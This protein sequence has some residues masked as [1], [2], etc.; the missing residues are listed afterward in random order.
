MFHNGHLWQRICSYLDQNPSKPVIT[1]SNTVCANASDEAANR[2]VGVRC[3]TK[4][5]GSGK[6]TRVVKRQLDLHK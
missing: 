3:D 2:L 6:A 4:Q 5:P 1:G